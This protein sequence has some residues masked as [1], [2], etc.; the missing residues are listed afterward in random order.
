MQPASQ[1]LVILYFD[2]NV[3][4]WSTVF[5]KVCGMDSYHAHDVFQTRVQATAEC[6]DGCLYYFR[7]ME[8]L[9]HF[10]FTL[11]YTRMADGVEILYA[12]SLFL[13]RV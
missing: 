10:I 13:V 7:I 8:R 6:G 4:P 12:I 2:C 9:Y 11:S 3:V 1:L 5:G